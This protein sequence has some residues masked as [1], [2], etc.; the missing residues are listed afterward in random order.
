M[1]KRDGQKKPPQ[2]K[3]GLVLFVEGE[4]EKVFY[5][6]LIEHLTANNPDKK[7]VD[8]VFVRN[9]RGVGNYSSKA[10]KK[11]KNEILR[12]NPDVEFT[13]VCCYDAD[14]FKY[15][16]KPPRRLERS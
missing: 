9:V 15:D 1:V 13:V 4:T 8:K 10:P 11:F 2:S 16:A 5:D 12:N 7:R 3:K 14:R 6:K